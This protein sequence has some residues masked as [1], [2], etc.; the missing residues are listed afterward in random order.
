MEAE[1]TKKARKPRKQPKVHDEVVGS[2]QD[3]PAYERFQHW[4]PHI[5]NITI[6]IKENNKLT[7]RD[8]SALVDSMKITEMVGFENIESTIKFKISYGNKVMLEEF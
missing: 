1:K 3:R 5:E 8:V 2:W 7:H 4:K 6:K